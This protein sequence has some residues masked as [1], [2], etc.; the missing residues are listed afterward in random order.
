MTLDKKAKI[1]ETRNGLLEEIKHNGS[2]SEKY[3]RVCGDLNLFEHFPF[4]FSSLSW[5]V[6]ISAFAFLVGVPVGVAISAAGLKVLA[7][8][9]G[10]KKYAS[11]I[12]KKHDKIVLLAKTKVN[13]I[14][15]LIYKILINS[16]ISHD[17][18]VSV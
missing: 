9:A 4:L 6:S 2:M 8:T 13:T 18:F 17:K 12:R 5:C 15:V 7:I 16:Y 1:Y 11:I 3:K 10:I 14:G